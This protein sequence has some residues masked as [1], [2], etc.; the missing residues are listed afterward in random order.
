[1]RK[2]KKIVSAGVRV[3]VILLDYLKSQNDGVKIRMREG[4]L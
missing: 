1:M 3:L 2:Q 4:K